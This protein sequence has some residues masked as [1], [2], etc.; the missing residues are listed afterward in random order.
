MSQPAQAAS[1]NFYMVPC[2]W[3]AACLPF[4]RGQCEERPNQ[5]I[6]NAVLM[7]TGVSDDEEKGEQKLPVSEKVQ[8]VWNL[9]SDI[10][11]EQDFFLVGS[12][13]WTLISEKFGYDEK[14]G[15][16]VVPQPDHTLAVDLGSQKIGIPVTGRFSFDLKQT[17]VVSDD[18]DFNDLVS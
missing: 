17:D 9:R 3:M 13:V 11:H 12:N 2:S 16:K 8:R 18:D 15:Y 5:K 1:L 14:L 6:V 4:L 10:E 7:V